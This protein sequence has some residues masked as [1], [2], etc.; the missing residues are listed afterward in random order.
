MGRKVPN[1]KKKTKIV[2]QQGFGYDS[3]NSKRGRNPGLD[4][5]GIPKDI[6]VR[7]LK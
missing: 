7:W 4:Y 5:N 2:T 6:K 1:R 3:T